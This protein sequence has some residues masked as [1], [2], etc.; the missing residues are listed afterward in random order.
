MDFKETWR[1]YNE[2]KKL[3]DQGHLSA[4]EFE[5]RV[6]EMTVT[7]ARENIWQIG[8]KTGK[9]YR[10][11]GQKW[12]EDIPQE[13]MQT[14]NAV[15]PKAA[16]VPP[17]HPVGSESGSTY[18]DQN[19]PGKNTWLS[20]FLIIGALGLCCLVF[21]VG[22]WLA[23]R[24]NL[25]TVEGM[26]VVSPV[27]PP[28]IAPLIPSVTAVAPLTTSPEPMAGPGF[29]PDL[30]QFQD[31]FSNPGSGWNTYQDS[32]GSTGYS[33][34]GFRIKVTTS[35]YLLWANPKQSLQNDISINVDATKT[36]G[37][38]ENA[39]GV[40]CRYQDNANFY[41][42]VIT[43]D[44]YAGIS[45]LKNGEKIWLTGDSLIPSDAIN[46]GAAT[47]SI[48]ADCAG[49]TLTLYVNN[50]QIVSV[51]DSSF[52]GGDVGLIAK[53]YGT[54]GVDILFDNFIVFKAGY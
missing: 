9:W 32:N 10:H 14:S 30:V 31:D 25:I 46:Q 7:D 33:N 45:M 16:Y 29:D 51:T 35:D 44:G 15:S 13:F 50:Q 2:L 18:Q 36:G 53:A 6:N 11:D 43:S 12:V 23:W 40:I 3:F 42:F 39:F 19:Q 27:I 34:G 47:N 38:D 41:Y 5:K 28:T 48:R 1:V 17:T 37:S 49:S 24:N 21:T 52:S 20:G 22:S 26:P 8:V 4:D 54:P